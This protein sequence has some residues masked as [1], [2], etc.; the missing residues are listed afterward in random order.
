MSTPFPNNLPP[1]CLAELEAL[2]ESEVSRFENAK[3]S[4]SES[5]LKGWFDLAWNEQFCV[6]PNKFDLPEARG[7]IMP[8][9]YIAWDKEAKRKTGDWDIDR[10]IRS[11]RLVCPHCGGH[12]HDEQKIWMDK[13]GVWIPTRE[14][15]GHKGYQ[16]SAL[17][18]PPLVS[19]EVDPR[20]KSRLA[21]RALKFLEA[22]EEG[23]MKAFI[24]STLAEVDVMQEHGQNKI[25][26]NSQPLSQPDW[27][28]MLTA[29]FHKN[30]PY[31]W[32]VVRK[33]CA[34]KLLPPFAINN[35][36][37][38]FV[39]LLD[40]P[41]N[42]E[43][44]RVAAA[45]VDGFE[46]AWL[47]LAELV[48]FKNAENH[49]PIFDFLI[50]QKIVGQKLVTF[51]RDVGNSNTMDFRRALYREM[52]RH[53]FGNPDAIPCPRG[54]DSELIAAGHLELS[55]EQV[56]HELRDI[57]IEFQVGKGMTL[58]RRCVAVDCGYAEKFD[59][60][61]LRQC[62]ERADHFKWYDPTSRN[63]PAQFHGLWKKGEQAAPA[64]HRFCMPTAAD[65][66]FALRGKPTNRPLG[67]GKI[68]HELSIHVEDP[69]YGQIEAGSKMVEVLEVPQGLFW[70]RKN[71]LRL[72]RTKQKYTISPK[73]SLFPKHYLPDG[74]RTEESNFKLADY[75]KQLNEQFFNETTK[76]V[77][78][79]HGRGGSQNR[80]HPYHLDDCET[81][82]VAL[83]T[84]HEF[85][86]DSTKK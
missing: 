33:W 83:A 6:I 43:P 8:R 48:R 35:G 44:K 81:Y 59:R 56:W 39:P 86:D 16:L 64:K 34:F 17:Y 10:V 84:H 40:L 75:E 2:R 70:I 82:Q 50:S 66:W 28:P 58:D 23:E 47:V 36:R 55:G 14:A 4:L 31:I 37:P 25:E 42:E 41:G 52:S 21:G 72:K 5:N 79:K 15:H 27:V 67:D 9:A 38:D 74:T 11:T 80:A 78:P 65:G 1:E 68:N 18:A 63:N 49:S 77:E 24:N 76:K 22:H 3:S 60:E 12:I 32:F 29:D 61:V 53:Q 85:F 7:V 73:V 54:G 51:F 57:E 69:Y 20:H 45:L 62:F 26:I 46:P 71:D 13:N 19:A 30:H